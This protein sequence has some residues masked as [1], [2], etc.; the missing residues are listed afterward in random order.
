M[1]DLRLASTYVPAMVCAVKSALIAMLARVLVPRGGASSLALCVAFDRLHLCQHPAY[2]HLNQCAFFDSNAVA[3]FV[4]G[5]SVAAYERGR[6][7]W[8]GASTGSLQ[9][10]LPDALIAAWMLLACRR[11][12]LI[13]PSQAGPAPRWEAGLLLALFLLLMSLPV[14][15]TQTIT[16]ED[17]PWA[18]VRALGFV[19]AVASAAYTS[20]CD[21]PMALL[22][23]AAPI[24]LA[25][26]TPAMCFAAILF[27]I[28]LVRWQ[29][30]QVSGGTLS[31]VGPQPT[32]DVSHSIGGG[33]DHQTA[34]VVMMIDEETLEEEQRRLREALARHKGGY[35]NTCEKKK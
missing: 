27:G 6:S 28:T 8:I 23:R 32:P 30:Q 9:Q 33:E 1:V 19:A 14:P 15:D 22:M 13:A 2:L 18:A 3:A 10:L 5:V 7:A 26:L 25:A 16:K 17:L 35:V 20:Q 11:Q 12:V 34:S 4:L 31:S 21:T 29:Q 24:F